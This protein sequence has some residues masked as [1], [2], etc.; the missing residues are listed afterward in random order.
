MQEK[1][2]MSDR[3][4]SW[5]LAVILGLYLALGVAYS[6]V[7]PILESPDEVLNYANIR[8]L[9]EERRLPVLEATELSKGHHP[10]L[11]YAL[12]G[13]L[14]GWIPN[15]HLDAV[16]ARTNPFWAYRLW[17][18]GVDNK[19]LYLHDPELEGWPYRDVALGIHLMRWFSLLMGAGA[20]V[21]V[22]YTAKELFP[23][24]RSLAPAAAA[25]VAFNP[26]FLYVQGSVHNDALTNLWAALALWGIARYW[27]RGPSTRRA[28]CLGLI[29]GLGILTKI[30]FL[31][32]VP[33]VSL[34]M[35][36]RS[37]LD[38]RTNPRWWQE[39][40]R[41]ALIGGGLTI[42]VSG[43]WF[44]RNQLLYGDPTSMRMQAQIW[45]IRDNAPD[46]GAALRELGFLHNSFWGVFGYSHLSTILTIPSWYTMTPPQLSADGPVA[47]VFEPCLV[48]FGVSLGDE[49]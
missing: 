18:P 7:N 9:A 44:V 39:S 25:L 2:L 22:Y 21:A 3:A 10:P 37:W 40:I 45:G 36:W 43:W 38:R 17:E 19:S 16:V 27:L 35:V 4:Q 49:A 11:Y 6:V 32:L 30:T 14:V 31:F 24:E 34:T 28:A 47:E 26:M 41:L 15:E 42:L 48:C 5:V 20:I 13:V 46:I 23:R 1:H 29:C 8:F 33:A 12:G